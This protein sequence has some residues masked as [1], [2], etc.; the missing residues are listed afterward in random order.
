[1]ANYEEIVIHHNP[2][3]KYKKQGSKRNKP[4]NPP[5]EKHPSAYGNS[6]CLTS[7]VISFQASNNLAS[8]VG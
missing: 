5:R 6:K 3:K 8:F 7:N 1:M 2:Q 4:K